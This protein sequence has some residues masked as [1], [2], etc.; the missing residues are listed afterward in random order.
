MPDAWTPLLI[1][2][3]GVAVLLYGVSKTAMPVLGVLAGPV[4]AAALGPT[5]ASAFAVPLLIAGDLVAL[6]IYR[7]HADWKLIWRIVPG[8]LLGFGVTALMFAFLDQRVIARILG[9]L[10]LT[11][12]FL[13]LWQRR[14]KSRQMAQ[15]DAAGE[16]WVEANPHV[17]RGAAAFFGTLAGMT[18]MAANAGG[19][20]MTLYLLKMRVPMLAFMGTSA[21]FFFILNVAKIPI[22]VGLG[23]LDVQSLLADLA[24]LPIM[25]VGTVLGIAVFRRM[26]QTLFANLALALSGLASLWLIIHG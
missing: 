26:N 16:V 5:T 8:V 13:E 12:V 11:S 17:H 18:T 21:W 2:V 23:L 24:F 19:T 10:I 6:S 7:Q 4:L 14:Q 25:L 20:A 15:A 9:V 3:V 22:V 1:A